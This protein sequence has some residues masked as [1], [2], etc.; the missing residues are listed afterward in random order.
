MGWA[1]ASGI[2][3]DII[4]AIK[5]VLPD[6]ETRKKV[7]LPIIQSFEDSDWDTQDECMGEDEAYDEVIKELHPTWFD[8]EEYE[9][10]EDD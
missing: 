9:L 1:S 10:E 5:P 8:D 6:K 4:S 2:M 7:Y 3:S